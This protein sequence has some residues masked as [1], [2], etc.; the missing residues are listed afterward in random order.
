[1]RQGYIIALMLVVLALGSASILIFTTRLTV[2]LS[3]R[4]AAAVRSQAL[5]LARS[6]AQTGQQGSQRVQ[7]PHGEAQVSVRSGQVTVALAGAQATILL[8]P[9]TERFTPASP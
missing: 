8:A 1:M 5:W 7:T 6:A 2:D 9:W 4:E 3:A